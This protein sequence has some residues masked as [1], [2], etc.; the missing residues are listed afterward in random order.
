VFCGIKDFL[1]FY[2]QEIWWVGF[3][4]VRKIEPL[5]NEITMSAVLHYHERYDGRGY[6][7]GLKG[8]EIPIWG[9]I[10]AIADSFDAM[11][12]DRPYK[13]AMRY[14]EAEDMQESLMKVNEGDRVMKEVTE[15]FNSIIELVKHLSEKIREVATAADEVS[16]A[17]QNIAAATEEQVATM[18][19]V[20]AA[21]GELSRTADEMDEILERYRV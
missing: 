5:A 13:K 3:E 6:P 1:I 21:A 2:F 7:K 19:E 10:M 11:T 4:I 18:E 14:E 9:R 17:V 16:Q 15:S 8:K 20:S 12:T